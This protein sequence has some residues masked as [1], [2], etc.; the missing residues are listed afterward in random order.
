MEFEF[1]A[2]MIG[3]A[4]AGSFIYSLF[5]I[6]ISI[7]KNCAKK[8]FCLLRTETDMW[9]PDACEKYMNKVIWR[10]RI[11]L[12]V[13]FGIILW[14]VPLIGVVGYVLGYMLKLVLTKSKTGPIRDNLFDSARIF[15]RFAKP[16]S[17][18][19][20]ADA[21]MEAIEK[22]LSDSIFRLI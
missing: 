8:L 9:Y 21:L 16:G 18:E 6:Q 5:G 2:W 13:I 1:Y 15:E 19:K 4:L 22:M 14:F 11:I 3:M 7:M 17:E 20:F 12:L 10:N